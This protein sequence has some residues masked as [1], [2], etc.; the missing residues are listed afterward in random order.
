[1]SNN[2][3]L[4]GV[5]SAAILRYFPFRHSTS[6]FFRV[7]QQNEQK[8]VIKSAARKLQ[9]IFNLF[10]NINNHNNIGNVTISFRLF[11]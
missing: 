10:R 7:F 5:G 11:S 2:F 3:N 9:E 6:T 1:M 8:F 4:V